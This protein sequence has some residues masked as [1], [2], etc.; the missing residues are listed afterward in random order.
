M[1]K[2]SGLLA[3]YIT[4][5]HVVEECGSERSRLR[6]L[7]E[8]LPWHFRYHTFTGALP[9]IREVVL[10][11]TG[12]SLRFEVE[13]VGCLFRTTQAES[14][15]LFGL[16]EA[17]GNLSQFRLDETRSFHLEGFNCLIFET[18]QLAGTGEVFA[19]GSTTT[20]IG[21]RLVQ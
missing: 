18:V 5:A 10:E 19:L 13:F 4:F 9:N 11:L 6:A 8:T 17:S 21:I 16:V 7:T 1:S 3:G 20:R 12:A 15:S 2:V 14:L